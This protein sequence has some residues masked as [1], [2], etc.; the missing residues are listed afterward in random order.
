VLDQFQRFLQDL[1][2]LLREP[3]VREVQVQDLLAVH[4]LRSD[5]GG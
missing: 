1:K 2:A 5:L 3:Q 4:Q